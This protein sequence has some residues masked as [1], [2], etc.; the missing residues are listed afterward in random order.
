MDYFDIKLLVSFCKLFEKESFSEAAKELCITQP[1][2]STHISKLEK[3]LGIQLVQR[4]T[5]QIEFTY[6]GKLFYKKAKKIIKEFNEA[7]SL[8]DNIKGIKSGTI[9]I[10]ASTLPGEY[11]LPSIIKNFKKL[12]PDI[13]I[14]IH[15]KDT[16]TII[17]EIYHGNYDF[18]IVG[19]RVN[20]RY[21]EF[22]EIL[23]DEIYFVGLNDKNIP[24][25]ITLKEINTLPII[26]REKGSGTFH[27]VTKKIN[28]SEN[29]I[30]LIAGS[31]Q[32]VKNLIK[33]GLGCSFLSYTAIKDELKSG[34][35]KIIEIKG[36]T[37]IIRNFYFVKK[38]N[39]N[40]NPSSEKF[41]ELMLKFIKN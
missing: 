24:E 23:E 30:K 9:D 28:I 13:K 37:P 32:A 14:N 2:L 3:N 29:D 7:K 4:S 36:V 16:F 26:A 39:I 25:T 5:K 12:Y 38:R 8:I 31:L 21:L 41:Y 10:G 22:K 15:I 34:I 11:I 40:L 19:S 18:G 6:A 20:D 33:E 17:D 35:F 1:A 27:S